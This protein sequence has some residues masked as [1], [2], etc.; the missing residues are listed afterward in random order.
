M[1]LIVN[2]RE[3]EHSGSGTLL[4][5]LTEIGANPEQ[6]AIVVNGKIVNRN[7]RTSFRLEAG[8]RVEIVTMVGG[9]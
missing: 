2:D 7:E 8:D 6:T 3:H 1:K 9:G 4:E 5:L